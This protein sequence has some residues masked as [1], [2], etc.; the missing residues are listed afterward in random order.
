[1]CNN[2]DNTCPFSDTLT[3]IV[4][5][6]NAGSCP[7]ICNQTCDRPFLGENNNICL[8][9]TR[10]VT[11]FTCP[12]NISWEM[13]YG[14]GEQEQ[15]SSVFRCESVEGCCATFRVLAPNEDGTYSSTNSFFTMNLKCVGAIKCLQDTFVTGL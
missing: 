1:M 7:D 11:I 8:Y 2:N 3:T 5:L 13:P 6:Q 14:Q 9:N 10:P 12:N 4:K 15:T